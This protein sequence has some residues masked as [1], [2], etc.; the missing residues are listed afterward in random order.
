MRGSGVSS[1]ISDMRRAV[2]IAVSVS[3]QAVPE[4]VSQSSGGR[5]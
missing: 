3:E 5:L 4:P 1:R 2:C